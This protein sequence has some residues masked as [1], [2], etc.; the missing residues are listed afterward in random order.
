MKTKYVAVALLF[1]VSCTSQPAKVE[2][3]QTLDYG[4][5]EVLGPSR[6]VNAPETALG[7]ATAVKD[8][9][10]LKATR[11]IRAKLGSSFGYR[12]AIIGEPKG[13]R[14]ALKFVMIFPS[15]GLLNPHT[16]K[17]NNRGEL[18][19]KRAIGK[20]HFDIYSF[21]EEW[22]MVPG[23]WTFEI[24]RENQKLSEQTFKVVSP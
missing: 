7:K 20:D 15:K 3:I 19:L 16:Q 6:T 11:T 22:E 18:T 2:K 13:K 12:Y 9:K 1:L 4:I 14:V 21:D 24:W 10:L 8:F 17:V 23:N 5:Y